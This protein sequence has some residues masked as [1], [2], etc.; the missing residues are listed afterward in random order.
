MEPKEKINRGKERKARRL[1]DYHAGI[2][3]LCVGAPLKSHLFIKI[4]RELW[5]TLGTPRHLPC[6][7]EGQEKAIFPPDAVG[8]EGAAIGVVLGEVGWV[9]PQRA[10]PAPQAVT[11]RQWAVP[12]ELC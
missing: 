1:T 6:P 2:T 5:R 3:T 7:R 8:G 12:G 4:Y 11:W 10:S 9:R